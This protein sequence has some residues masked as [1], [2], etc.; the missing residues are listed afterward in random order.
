MGV[1]SSGAGLFGTSTTGIAIEGMINPSS[2]NT[3]VEVLRL[4]R[5]S[6][7]TASNNIGSYIAY[8]NKHVDGNLYESGRIANKITDVTV[9][10]R[11]SNFEWWLADSGTL[12]KTMELTGAGKL[13]VANAKLT[14]L[15]TY[16]D[17]TAATGGGLTAGQLYRTAAGNVMITY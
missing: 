10:T 3:M 5:T 2:T 8:R 15:A 16:A 9:L 1:S 4:N 7:G 13:I 12:A 11:T 17:N 6:S 14:G